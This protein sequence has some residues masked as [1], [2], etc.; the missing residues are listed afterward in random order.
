MGKTA[1]SGLNPCFN[2]ILKYGALVPREL[3]VEE[4]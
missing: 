1:Y 3:D 4:S 2:G